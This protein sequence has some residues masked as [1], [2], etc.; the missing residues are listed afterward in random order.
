MYSSKNEFNLLLGIKDY[1]SSEK[2]I[3]R[4]IGE[5]TDDTNI[6]E[7]LEKN[8]QELLIPTDEK[9]SDLVKFMIFKVNGIIKAI[10]GIIEINEIQESYTPITVIKNILYLIRLTY[11]YITEN[12][13]QNLSSFNDMYNTVLQTLIPQWRERFNFQNQIIAYYKELTRDIVNKNM[14]SIDK[15]KKAY[16]ICNQLIDDTETDAAKNKTDKIK[17]LISC[18]EQAINK[19]K[20]I[21]DENIENFHK[22]IQN[23]EKEYSSTNNTKIMD[24]IKFITYIIYGTTASDLF[25]TKKYTNLQHSINFINSIFDKVDNPID[26]LIEKLNIYVPRLYIMM[27]LVDKNI[28]IPQEYIEKI[29]Y[30]IG[31]MIDNCISINVSDPSNAISSSD[32]IFRCNATKRELLSL[33]DLDKQT[34]GLVGDLTDGTNSLVSYKTNYQK[35]KKKYINLKKYN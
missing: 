10:K 23:L 8:Q 24:L 21:I 17:L 11:V 26:E 19:Y 1:I 14:I 20:N 33:L 32:A 13:I 6:I 4:L 7:F 31:D 25:K 2:E 28:I 29:K 18:N 12:S 9:F 22:F 27:K 16:S 5:I 30:I 34:G 3:D 35:Y 15:I